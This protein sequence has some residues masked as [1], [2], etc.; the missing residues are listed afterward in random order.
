MEII[1]RGGKGFYSWSIVFGWLVGNKFNSM[2]QSNNTSS[3]SEIYGKR[4]TLNER[5]KFFPYCKVGSKTA[6]IVCIIFHYITFVTKLIW[7]DFFF[8]YILPQSK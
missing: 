6:E 2:H 3:L 4:V 5:K 7:N 1:Q 8:S